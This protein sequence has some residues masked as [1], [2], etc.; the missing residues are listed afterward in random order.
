MLEED[1]LLLSCRFGEGK[2]IWESAPA[3]RAILFPR[4][5]PGLSSLTVNPGPGALWSKEG[6]LFTL[7]PWPLAGPRDRWPSACQY[8]TT[9]QFPAQEVEFKGLSEV[10]RHSVVPAAHNQPPTSHQRP[11]IQTV[12]REHSRNQ[13]LSVSTKQPLLPSSCLTDRQRSRGHWQETQQSLSTTSKEKIL[14]YSKVNTLSAGVYLF[15]WY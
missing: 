6:I 5:G 12:S 4:S 10:Q 2:A 7:Y 3:K 13:V 15:A 9:F 14:F 11:K 8:S 1:W